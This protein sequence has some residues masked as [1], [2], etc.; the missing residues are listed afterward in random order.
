[1]LHYR[2]IVPENTEELSTRPPQGLRQALLLL[3]AS[4]LCNK[5][6]LDWLAEG[7]RI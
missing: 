5:G 2:Q 6:K 3:S 4:Q 1:M 7:C